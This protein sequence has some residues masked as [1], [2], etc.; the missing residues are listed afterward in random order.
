MCPDIDSAHALWA[1]DPYRRALLEGYML[2]GAT[3]D[4]IVSDLDVTTDLVAAYHACFFDV[5]HRKRHAVAAMV[6]GGLPHKNYKSHD[7][8]GIMHRLAWFGGLEAIRSVVGAGGDAQHDQICEQ[9]F[10]RI[11][12][13]QLPEVALSFAYAPEH[14]LETMRV[15]R[16]ERQAAR[17]AQRE[18]EHESA[19]LQHLRRAVEDLRIEVADPHDTFDRVDAPQRSA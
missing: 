5:R 3:D 8:I 13:R 19:V 14:V 9:V 11:I 15:L 6:F 7:V 17:E 4:D 18:R 10:Y 1:T 2:A 12:R 16:E